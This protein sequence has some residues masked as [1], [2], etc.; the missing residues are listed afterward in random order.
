MEDEREQRGKAESRLREVELK[1]F[2]VSELESRFHEA[3]AKLSEVADLES[4]LHEAEAKMFEVAE[5][6]VKLVAAE[7][8]VAQLEKEV[9]TLT[10]EKSRLVDRID[11]LEQGNER[12]F[13]MKEQQVN[14]TFF[15][16]QVA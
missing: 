5:Y 7:A 3:E 16:S 15:L 6:E 14:E 11:T 2:E 13:Q 8:K 10:T 4:R 1:L 12:F 9:A